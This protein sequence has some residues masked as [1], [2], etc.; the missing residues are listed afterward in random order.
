MTLAEC[1]LDVKH[2]LKLG[3]VKVYGDMKEKTYIVLLFLPG[4]ESRR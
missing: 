3:S 4:R 2:K 1:C